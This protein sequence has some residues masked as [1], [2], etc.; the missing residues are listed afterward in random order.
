M[1][2]ATENKFRS[3]DRMKRQAESARYGA[4]SP[5]EMLSIKSGKLMTKDEH[6]PLISE[7]S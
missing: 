4:T 3:L 5:V 6:R 7:K 1:A 2:Q